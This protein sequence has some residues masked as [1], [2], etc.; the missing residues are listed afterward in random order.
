VS[1]RWLKRIFRGCDKAKTA[2]RD[3]IIEYLAVINSR[4]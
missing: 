4:K 1:K 3:G 2:M